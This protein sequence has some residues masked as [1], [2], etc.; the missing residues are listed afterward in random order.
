MVLKKEKEINDGYQ[1]C[2]KNLK[3]ELDVIRESSEILS[4]EKK[5]A[6]AREKEVVERAKAAESRAA[7]LEQE[8]S[9]LKANP[10]VEIRKVVVEQYQS[11]KDFKNTLAEAAFPEWQT[12]WNSCQRF[13]TEGGIQIPEGIHL[14]IFG[15][16]I[17]KGI[18]TMKIRTSTQREQEG[19]KPR[20]R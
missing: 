6:E 9:A 12:G 3:D 8:L 1:T 17:R 15:L 20:R 2:I 11:S 5:D 4:S 19:T 16:S 10:S 18:Q 13:L 7:S 14:K